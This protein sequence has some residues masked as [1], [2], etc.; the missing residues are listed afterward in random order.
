[1]GSSDILSIIFGYENTLYKIIDEP[2]LV[3][4]VLANITDY[5]LK[6][7]KKI[8][9]ILPLYYEGSFIYGRNL[10][11]PGKSFPLQQD[12]AGSIMSPDIYKQ[13][14]LPLDELVI[15][16]YPNLFY[17][18]HSSTY[19]V[20]L[21]SLLT[22]DK[23]RVIEVWLDLSGPSTEKLIYDFNRVLKSGKSLYI[24]SEAPIEQVEF[25]I[26]N[27]ENK[28]RGVFI[29]LKVQSREEA[30]EKLKYLSKFI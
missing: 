17:H 11:L 27:L 30:K 5:Y 20:L 25:L 29:E 26:K 24:W 28:G 9:E 18:L 12:A 10:W 23:L 3:K 4:K 21:D 7:R 6:L 14:L 16:E 13:F 8:F 22:L 19:K 1:S 2:E 15:N